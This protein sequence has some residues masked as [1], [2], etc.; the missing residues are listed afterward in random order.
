[1]VPLKVKDL[2]GLCDLKIYQNG[3]KI[4]VRDGGIL[5]RGNL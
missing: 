3:E 2:C 4:D 1:M 5:I